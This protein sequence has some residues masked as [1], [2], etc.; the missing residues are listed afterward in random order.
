MTS[1]TRNSP[2]DYFPFCLSPNTTLRLVSNLTAPGVSNSTHQT[3]AFMLRSLTTSHAANERLDLISHNAYHWNATSFT[4]FLYLNKHRAV[5]NA[6]TT[7]LWCEL[8]ELPLPVEFVLAM[9]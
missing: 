9:D 4:C 7:A 8:M 5:H 3:C 2:R 1:F 6:R